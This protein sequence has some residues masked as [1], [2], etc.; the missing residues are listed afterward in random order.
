VLEFCILAHKRTQ[1]SARRPDHH[2]ISIG[3]TK[4]ASLRP[5]AIPGTSLLGPASPLPVS[6]SWHRGKVSRCAAW[7][8]PGALK[9]PPLPI[10]HAAGAAHDDDAPLLEA[11]P[12]PRPAIGAPFQCFCPDDGWM[13][14]NEL[15][16][17][18]DDQARRSPTP[19]LSILLCYSLLSDLIRENCIMPLICN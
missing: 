10:V 12:M 11:I 1:E 3:R 14:R 19:T 2:L 7:P 8:V 5:S 17:E 16:G 13:I 6:F 15:N 18:E 9:D 4:G